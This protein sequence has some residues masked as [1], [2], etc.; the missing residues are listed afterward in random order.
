MIT[1]ILNRKYSASSSW[2]IPSNRYMSNQCEEHKFSANIVEIFI[3]Q[4][5]IYQQCG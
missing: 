2:L 3:L 5:L 1:D 4:R